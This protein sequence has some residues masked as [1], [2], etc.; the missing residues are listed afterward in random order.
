MQQKFF[1][2]EPFT[3]KKK[4]TIFSGMKEMGAAHD[5]LDFELVCVD[6]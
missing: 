3:T 5:K 1:E 4:Q 6:S 2:F